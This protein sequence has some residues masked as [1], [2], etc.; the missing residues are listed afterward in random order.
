M[1]NLF[2]GT[3]AWGDGWTIH[4]EALESVSPD[5]PATAQGLIQSYDS[6]IDK[7]A[8]EWS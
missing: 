8:A 1:R 7:I 3:F 4:R 6:V 2:A 5:V